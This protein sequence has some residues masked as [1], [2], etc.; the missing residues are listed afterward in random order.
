MYGRANLNLR[1]ALL[2]ERYRPYGP[3]IRELNP[4]HDTALQRK[5]PDRENNVLF[6]IWI[7]A[8]PHVGNSTVTIPKHSPLSKR[9]TKM[10]NGGHHD[11]V[12]IHE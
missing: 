3:A 9:K 5:T 4:P 2:G 7:N 10:N 1:A 12:G 11:D 8:N 6:L